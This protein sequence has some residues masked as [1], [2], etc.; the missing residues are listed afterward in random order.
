MRALAIIFTSIMILWVAISGLWKIDII[1]LLHV[2]LYYSSSCLCYIIAYSAIEADSPTLSLI[3]FITKHP[4]GLPED[5]I[6]RFLANRPFV[7]ARLFALI[8]SGLIRKQ[9]DSYIVAGR[10]SLF[11]RLILSFRKLYGPISK[12]G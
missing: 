4:K 2:C 10:P 9:G 12:G 1:T 11:F 6:S 3:Q 8:Q 5:E 7:Q